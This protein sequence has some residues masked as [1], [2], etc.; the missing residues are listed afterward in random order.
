M[1][2]FSIVFSTT[3][4]L[5][6]SG[7]VSLPTGPSV[8]VLPGT[9]LS[10]DQFRND[11]AVCQQYAYFQVG[12]TTANQA[13]VDSGVTSAAV[14]TALGAAAGAALGGGR[15]AAIGAG[16]G[17]VGGSLVGTG[18]AGSSMYATQDRYDVAYIQCMYA[19]GHQVPVSGQ[20]SGAIPQQAA[21]PASNIPPPPPGSPPPPPK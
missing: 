12:G 4:I 14:G 17:L 20:F 16:T 19:K 13:A 3:V 18:A 8:M 1:S 5:A 21:P 2:R 9:G 11:D 10:F 15:G 6:V 7:C